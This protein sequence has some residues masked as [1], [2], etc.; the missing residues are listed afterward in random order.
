MSESPEIT[1]TVHG[2]VGV[3]KSAVS[4]AILDALR[5]AGLQCA[6]DEEQSERNL[7]TGAADIAALEQR[8]T[9]RLQETNPSMV[10]RSPIGRLEL[11]QGQ[12][13]ALADFAG[14]PI[15][16][17][18][19][20]DQDVLVLTL[21]HGGHSGPGLYA[22][23]E[24]VP[25]AG[26]FYLGIP[27]GDPQLLFADDVPHPRNGDE[28]RWFM[29]GAS[30]VASG[31]AFVNAGDSEQQFVAEGALE[32]PEG[33]LTGQAKVTGQ[34][35]DWFGQQ[36]QEPFQGMALIDTAQG[37]LSTALDDLDSSPDPRPAGLVKEAMA[38]IKQAMLGGLHGFHMA[39]VP[40][41]QV[42][43]AEYFTRAS[44][45]TVSFC[46][47]AAKDWPEWAVEADHAMRL[48][49]AARVGLTPSPAQAL[50]ASR[51]R[52]HEQL[53]EMLGATD[54][55]AAAARIG[56]LV[57]LELLLQSGSA[58]AGVM[59]IAN[60]RR[61]QIDGEGFDPE[62]DHQYPRGQLVS[63]ALGYLRLAEI[64]SRCGTE[65]A[66]L[67]DEVPPGWPWPR[68]WWKPR[69]LERNLVRAAALIAADLDRRHA[70]KEDGHV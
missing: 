37:Y 27:E 60:E 50:Q 33:M 17:T 42:Y 49:V 53:L 56:E 12:I 30:A 18:P 39:R 34:A 70:A 7:G 21:A 61:R 48:G 32:L 68:A 8:P 6:W 2:Q 9:I 25:E 64:E 38:C 11:R 31:R 54:H 52:M 22:H 3:G 45:G 63:A 19:D 58:G 46:R 55:Q 23:F 43:A 41:T 15:R 44:D 59:A 20:E 62:G 51:Y 65:A 66:K 69:D 1:I 40:T 67:N 28:R 47:E 14:E 4:L 13:Q 10:G 36:P 16:G 26:A 5:A 35:V 29:A 24:D 57:G